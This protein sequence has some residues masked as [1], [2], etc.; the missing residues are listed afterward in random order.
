MITG[1][2]R[3]TKLRTDFS[4]DPSNG[5]I[6]TIGSREIAEFNAHQIRGQKEYFGLVQPENESKATIITE[7]T[8]GIAA[9]YQSEPMK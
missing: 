6:A 9:G 1:K 2:I 4:A 8:S 3:T 5:Q 7:G